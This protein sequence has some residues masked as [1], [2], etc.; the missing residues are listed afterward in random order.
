MSQIPSQKRLQCLAQAGWSDVSDRI[1]AGLCHDLNGRVTSLAGMVQLLQLD[2]D[3]A[4]MSPFLDQEVSRLEGS[5]RMVRRLAGEQ[6]EDPEPLHLPEIVPDLVGL[7]GKHRHLE[8]LETTLE[9]DPGLLPVVSRW[10]LLARSILIL[11]SCRVRQLWDEIGESRYAFGLGMMDAPTSWPKSKVDSTIRS[12]SRHRRP[13]PRA[14]R[15]WL[16]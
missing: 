16:R 15:R 6:D 3:S 13:W 14:W 7:F 4:S 12:R 2:E 1:L 11:L 9:M 8:G 10:T 5:V